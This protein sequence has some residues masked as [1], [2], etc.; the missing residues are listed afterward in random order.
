[1]VRGFFREMNIFVVRSL[2]PVQIA[3][4][5]AFLFLFNFISIKVV[6]A[7]GDGCADACD[8]ILN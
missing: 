6:M 3:D 8:N 2:D 7:E 4:D 5:D 1:M